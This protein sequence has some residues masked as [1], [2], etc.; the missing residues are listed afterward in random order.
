MT[1]RAILTDLDGTLLEPNGKACQ[2]VVEALALLG[3]RRIPVLPV[4]SKTAAEVRCILSRLALPGPAGFENGA[5]VVTAEGTVML[6]PAAVPSE[7]LREVA[8]ELR[9]RTGCGL[10]TLEEVDDDELSSLTGLSGEELAHARQRQATLPLL[11]GQQWDAALREVAP[12]EVL[13]VR[14]NRFLHLQGRHAKADLVPELLAAIPG[15]GLVVGCGD[16]PND[17]ELLQGVDRAVIVPSETGPHPVLRAALPDSFVAPAPHGR[18]WA[19]AVLA[20]CD[21]ER[22]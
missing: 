14:G 2:E 13:L 12:A 8:H 7:A 4:T 10:R 21:L 16:S 20:L 17:L 6:R 18:G 5:G 15:A 11:V 1:V 22:R 19:R 3:Q 9:R